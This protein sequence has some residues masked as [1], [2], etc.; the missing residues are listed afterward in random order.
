MKHQIVLAVDDDIS[1]R[2]LVHARLEAAG[3]ACDVVESAEQAL[4]MMQRHLYFAVVCDIHM[5]GMDGVHA[6][7]ALK[8]INP[9][10]QIIMLTADASVEQVIACADRGAVD[11]FS[12]NGDYAELVDMVTIILNR[13][14]RWAQWIGQKEGHS[15]TTQ[16]HFC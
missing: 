7:S 3:I 6:I 16:A 12:K 14:E 2:Q 15:A 10:V 8:E 13:R 4:E 5:S 9:L 1:I 11:F